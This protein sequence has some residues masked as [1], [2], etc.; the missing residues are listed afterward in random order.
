MMSPPGCP[1][2]GLDVT[3]LFADQAPFHFFFF[4]SHT[5]HGAFGGDF[6]GH[7]FHGRRDN[8]TGLLVGTLFGLV[9]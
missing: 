8:Q 1:L 2:Q 9:L 6:T 5:R 3:A 4:E 7:A